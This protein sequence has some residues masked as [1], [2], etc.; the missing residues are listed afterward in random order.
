MKHILIIDD[1]AAI[2]EML[3]YFLTR[4]GY[5][6]DL[7]ENGLAGELKLKERMPD[8]VISDILMPHGDG[9]EL[10]MRLRKRFPALRFIAISGGI[11]DAQYDPLPVA[12]M[13]G[14]CRTFPKPLD[15]NELYQAVF[16][17]IGEA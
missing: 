12:K 13:L 5:S 8:L 4:K 7:A 10:L 2:R 9:L 17:F 6:V 1:D 15:L 16:D 14:A 3:H 11:R